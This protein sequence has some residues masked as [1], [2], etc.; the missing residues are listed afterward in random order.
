[1]ATE[2]T[3][4]KLY[5]LNIDKLEDE[6][7]YMSLSDEEFKKRS[8]I[9]YDTIEEFIEDYNDE[10]APSDNLYYCRYI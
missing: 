10:C 6:E 5:F 9:S 7:T 2:N 1:M 8:E 4:K 3:Q